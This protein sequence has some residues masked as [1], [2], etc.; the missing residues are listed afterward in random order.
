MI[1]SI[2]LF[3]K[4]PIPNHD[5]SPAEIVGGGASWPAI[6]HGAYNIADN[7]IMLS[8][9]A[10]TKRGRGEGRGLGG[11]KTPPSTAHDP[12]SFQPG[13]EFIEDIVAPLL[14]DGLGY[15]GECPGAVF[16]ATCFDE[17]FWIGEV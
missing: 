5:A 6:I 11:S 13:V 2:L 1:V 8:D 3:T 10:P 9:A 7:R 17:A 4:H 16:S 12:T 14:G 15:L